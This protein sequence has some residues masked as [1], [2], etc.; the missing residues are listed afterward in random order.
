M[1][2][3]L[4]TKGHLPRV[5]RSWPGYCGC[6]YSSTVVFS[7]N[8]GVVAVG[9]GRHRRVPWPTMTSVVLHNTVLSGPIDFLLR[10]PPGLA[11]VCSAS[12]LHAPSGYLVQ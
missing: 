5:T 11:E 8:P 9:L 2:L 12:A 3:E 1:A 7:A 10:N 4:L 6:R